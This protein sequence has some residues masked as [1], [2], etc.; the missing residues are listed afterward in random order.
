MSCRERTVITGILRGR[1][2]DLPP[3]A[4]DL[5]RLRDYADARQRGRRLLLAGTSYMAYGRG[6]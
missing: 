4:V 3:T 1:L 2:A 6:R 5:E